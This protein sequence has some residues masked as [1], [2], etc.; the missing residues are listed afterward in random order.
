VVQ[1]RPAI[2]YHDPSSYDLKY[3][4][5]DGDAWQIEIVDS[6]GYAGYHTT[7]LEVDGQPAISYIEGLN[8]QLKYAP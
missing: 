7:L 6:T 5:F 8:N 2:S 3:A 1:G 4:R